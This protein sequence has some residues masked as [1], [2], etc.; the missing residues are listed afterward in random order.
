MGN[1]PAICEICVGAEPLKIPRWTK[2]V[3]GNIGVTSVTP[4]TAVAVVFPL[5]V[6]GRSASFGEL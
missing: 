6:K 2:I 1:R 3:L 4:Q 5:E